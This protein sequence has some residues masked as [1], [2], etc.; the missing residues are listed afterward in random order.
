MPYPHNTILCSTGKIKNAVSNHKLREC[1]LYS[2]FLFK[3]NQEVGSSCHVAPETYTCSR[4]DII[5]G[6][7]L[8]DGNPVF[9][10][11]AWCYL[12][13]KTEALHPCS[14]SSMRL[15][16][17]GRRGNGIPVKRQFG[18]APKTKYKVECFDQVI[19]SLTGIS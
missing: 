4:L 18:L 7:T 11:Y 17:K 10:T 3:Y 5:H 16:H 12:T 2:L 14:F 19:L 13:S 6:F 9:Q 8:C 1:N 15:Y